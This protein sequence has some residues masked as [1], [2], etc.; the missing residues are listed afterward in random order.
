[1]NRVE[2]KNASKQQLGGNIFS[3]KWMMALLTCLVVSVISG[4]IGA[5]PFV[6]AIAAIVV[7][8]PLE[9]GMSYV[10]LKISRTGEEANV[11]DL[12]EGFKQDFGGNILLMIMIAVFTFLWSLLFVIPGII[13]A[14][15]YSMA[16]YVK[17]DHPEYD[18]NACIKES[19]RI[20]DG[21][22]MELFVLMLSFIGWSIVGLC[23]CGIGLLW[24]EPYIE[25][26]YANFYNSIK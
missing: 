1:M 13:K 17:I 21:H 25:T 3:S 16:Y 15:S 26:A 9:Y 11:G 20:M 23:A 12:F 4:F 6:G 19:M 2:I 22:K 24:V 14:F 8:G 10:F 5:V 7:A 18:W